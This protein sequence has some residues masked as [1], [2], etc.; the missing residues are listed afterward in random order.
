P[1]LDPADLGDR[2]NLYLSKARALRHAAN[3]TGKWRPL[4]PWTP[5]PLSIDEY[6]ETNP[7]VTGKREL[8]VCTR[9]GRCFLGC[10][11]RAVQTLDRTLLEKLLND[12]KTYPGLRLE[13]LREVSHIQQASDG[14]YNVYYHDRRAARGDR[15]EAYNARQVVVAAGTLGT[16]E[17]LL[18]SDLCEKTLSL[19]ERLGHGFSGNGDLGGFI[20]ETGGHYPA[21]TPEA[22][23]LRFNVYPTRGPNIT[24]YV[25]FEA[26]GGPGAGPLQM[27]V[28]DGGIPPTLAAFTRVLLNFARR[29][30]RS[31]IEGAFNKLREL[32]DSGQLPR[33]E[34]ILRGSPRPSDPAS[35]QTEQ[36]MLE[37]VFYF[38]CMGADKADGRFF[39]DRRGRLDLKFASDPMKHPL[40]EKLGEIMRAM[41]VRMGGRFVP[42]TSLL[43][44]P[45][46]F[47]L[48]PLGGCAMGRDATEGVID[49]KGR[50][51][52]SGGAD[53]RAVYEGLYVMDA[54][55]FTGPVA[56][57]PTLTIVALALKIAENIPV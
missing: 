52:K 40:Y 56:V 53:P 15:V 3:V 42:F 50:V 9:L 34:P 1:G 35:Y 30:A 5:A 55:A 12:P 23:R 27:T 39:L 41:A 38:Q 46:L 28:E 36:E 24:S 57:N 49:T 4:S 16:N 31:D 20:V 10:T 2:E 14:T 54:S 32:D 11:P 44:R 37:N 33:L 6:D 22:D 25:Q 18:R 17:I 29:S 8:E 13:S 48:H 21:G 19:S 47:T 51:F 26:D 7:D 45:R 43:P